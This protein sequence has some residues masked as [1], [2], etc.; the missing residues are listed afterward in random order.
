MKKILMIII[1]GLGMREETH[2]NAIKNAG[3]TNFTNIWNNYPHSLLTSSGN[4][5]GL[6]EN[7]CS[8]SYLGYKTIG[9]GRKMP[10]RLSEG[11][12]FFDDANS[13]KNGN[14]LEFVN[15][16]KTKETRNLHVFTLLS[17]GGVL[18]HI[19]HLRGLLEDLKKRNINNKIY[20]HIITDG[21]DSYRYGFLNYYK[22]LTNLL[23]ENT[24]VATICGRSY[25]INP[26]KLNMINT[27]YDLLFNGKGLVS[28]S[29]EKI[30][31][32]CYQKKVTDKYIPPVKT[33][34]FDMI[35]KNDYL[36]FLNF[37]NESQRFLI[38]TINS[39]TL[40]DNTI[41]T[42]YE[43]ENRVQLKYLIKT[44]KIPN[45]MHK[46]LAN[47]GLEQVRIFE[48]CKASCL[49]YL[50]GYE[51]IKLPNCT[52]YIVD[53]PQ[54]DK[55]SDKPELN[56]LTVTKTAIKSMERDCDLV[57]VNFSNGD[58]IGHT[59]NYEATINALQVIDLCL[60]KLIDCA[61]EN[62]YKV[63]IVGTHGNV[64]TMIDENEEIITKN[65]TSPV[66]FIIMDNK[67]KLKNGSL[68]S[69]APTLLEYMDIAKPKEMKDTEI[70]IED[71]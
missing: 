21:E 68:C 45:T 46:Y 18:S 30:I 29:V 16:L 26:Q 47:I 69:F 32:L 27:Y 15:N 39:R 51:N 62:F 33:K 57:T 67:I 4:E 44:K 17:D 37:E 2:G 5:I 65:T 3:M 54:I 20:L 24:I 25:T 42:L 9:A 61:E 14:Y 19:N 10:S 11:L 52:D 12:D 58:V 7:Q 71:N 34:E 64:D 48:S 53:T 36:L 38:D 56:V 1:D 43:M 8:S 60:K 55:Y 50:D 13:N 49:Y 63:V 59:G 70:L 66:P 23:D 35:M 31:D 41:Y 22:E 28:P 40:K 6:P